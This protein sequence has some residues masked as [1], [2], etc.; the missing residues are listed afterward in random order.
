M[1]SLA[2]RHFA[3]KH[4][5]AKERLQINFTAFCYLVSRSSCPASR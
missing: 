3:S 4:D 5:V 2:K 1:K